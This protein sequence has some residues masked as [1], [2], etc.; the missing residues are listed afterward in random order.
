MVKRTV[1]VNVSLTFGGRISGMSWEEESASRTWD[2][3]LIWSLVVVVLVWASWTGVSCGDMGVEVGD[4][5]AA[6]GPQGPDERTFYRT[7]PIRHSPSICPPS[8]T[9][10]YSM[11]TTME[12]RTSPRLYSRS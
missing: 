8:A 10:Q 4:W 2:G 11:Q 3:V 6:R 1:G 9:I 12:L 7:Y 5:G